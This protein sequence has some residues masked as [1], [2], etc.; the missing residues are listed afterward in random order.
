MQGDCA[1]GERSD[2]SAGETDKLSAKPHGT[3][4]TPPYSLWTLVELLETQG[5]LDGY[6]NALLPLAEANPEATGALFVVNGMLNS[7]EL[8]ATPALFRQLWPKLLWAM[9]V[10]ALVAQHQPKGVQTGRLPTKG[11]VT[12]WLAGGHRRGAVGHTDKINQRHHRRIRSGGGMFC[13]ETLDQEQ[14]GLCVH[15]TVPP[16]DYSG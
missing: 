16:N 4:D 5:L 1:P 6:I 14:D 7:V 11:E 10:E 12:A 8:Y 15:E 9:S 2:I 13:F 3:R